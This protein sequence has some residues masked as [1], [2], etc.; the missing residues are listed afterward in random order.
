M[1]EP[2]MSNYNAHAFN[3]SRA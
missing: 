2:L 3:A 1:V